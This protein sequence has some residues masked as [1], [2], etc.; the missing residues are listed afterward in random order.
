MR[1]FITVNSYHALVPCMLNCVLAFHQQIITLLASKDAKSFTRCL[2]QC[3]KSNR[4]MKDTQNTKYEL[5]LV[6]SSP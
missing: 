5:E 6:F 4:L 1:L 2:S 3:V